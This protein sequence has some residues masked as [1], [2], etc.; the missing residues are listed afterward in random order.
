MGDIHYFTYESTG[1]H[2]SNSPFGRPVANNGITKASP[3]SSLT[4]Q[5]FSVTYILGGRETGECG[6]KRTSLVVAF[7]RVIT[8]VRMSR[9]Y[10]P[11]GP[12]T[13]GGSSDTFASD[14]LVQRA[15]IHLTPLLG[16]TVVAVRN[17]RIILR[18]GRLDIQVFKRIFALGT[19][20]TL[21]KL[22]KG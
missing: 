11:L 3:L 13:P 20:F 5:F 9:Q 14:E 21:N 15:S 17:V 16:V 1:S 2:L 6:T 18:L 22:L 12:N 19:D 8:R 7:Q 10:I 4:I